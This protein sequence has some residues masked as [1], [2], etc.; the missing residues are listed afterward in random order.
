MSRTKRLRKVAME[1]HRD[2]MLSVTSEGP[3]GCMMPYELGRF[4]HF[5]EATR[6]RET[7]TE[8]QRYSGLYLDIQ[9]L[10]L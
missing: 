6:V 5:R 1:L 9:I 8:T 2:S 10:E 7:S 4:H 3:T